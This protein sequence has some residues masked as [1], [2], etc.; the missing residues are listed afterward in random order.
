M[1]WSLR[2]VFDGPA[3]VSA[4]AGLLLLEGGN[5]GPSQK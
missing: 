3:G 1:S 5:L 2:T 4:L